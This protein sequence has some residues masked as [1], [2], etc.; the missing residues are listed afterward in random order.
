MT[1]AKPASGVIYVRQAFAVGG[2]FAL[3]PAVAGG[4]ALGL[5]LVIGLAG[6][7]AAG[8]W[9]LR[10]AVERMSLPLALLAALA[11]WTAASSLWSPWPGLTAA[12]VLATLAFGLLFSSAV[13]A[14]SL[15]R[16][17]L[18]GA[19][20]ATLVLIPLLAIEAIWDMPLNAA[21]QP[22]ASP[23]DLNQNPARG[24]V[25]MLAL[26]W[27]GLAWAAGSSMRW[28]WPAVSAAALAAGSIALQFGQL[29]TAIGFAIGLIFFALGFAA[30]RLAVLTPSILLAAWMLAAPFLTPIL[31]ASPALFEAVPHSWAV[32]IGIWRHTCER[33][34]EQ[35]WIGHG[36]DAARATTQY[37]TYDG[38]LMRVIP[39]HP[40]SA[41]LQIWYDLGLVG[42]LTAAILLALTGRALARAYARNRPGAAAAAAALAMFGMMANVGWNIWQEWWMATLILA[43]ALVSA[44]GAK[45]AT[46]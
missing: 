14:P 10:Q 38:E 21:A 2:F 40:H 37:A 11:I 46:N 32:R 28:R 44:L 16:L 43:G 39:V 4:G 27:P 26:L 42:A 19:F 35:P 23:E 24:V 9:T 29:S 45:A 30:P 36:L 18:A 31:V 7:A 15:A 41:S 12:K 22:D 1:P 8:P 25:V 17:A 20:A 3:L 6:A 13:A 33:I 5:P 34:L